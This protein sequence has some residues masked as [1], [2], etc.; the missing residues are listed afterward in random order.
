MVNYTVSNVQANHTISAEFELMTINI[1]L[2]NSSYVGKVKIRYKFGSGTWTN[3]TNPTVQGTTVTVPS[4]NPTMTVEA[5][6]IDEAYTFHQWQIYTGGQGPAISQNPYEFTSQMVSGIVGIELSLTAKTA[7]TITATAGTG[8][9]ISPSGSVTVYAGDD[10]TFQVTPNSGY[11]IKSV[12]LD[13]S[14]IEPDS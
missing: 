12:K 6:D 4:G 14:P 13:G 5:Y 10:K 2:A 3:I 1:N 11:R 8:G 9:T 7:Y